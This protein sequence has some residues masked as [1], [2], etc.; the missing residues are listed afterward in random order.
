MNSTAYDY[1]RLITQLR[2]NGMDETNLSQVAF[3][4]G[5]LSATADPTQDLRQEG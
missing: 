5:Q 1:G 3:A 2:T 4:A